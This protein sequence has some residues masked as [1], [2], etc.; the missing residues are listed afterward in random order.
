MFRRFAS[1][2]MTRAMLRKP[3]FV[4][5]G[6]ERPYLL[7]WWLIPRNPIFNVYLHQFFRSDDD[8]ALHDHPW[9]NCSIVLDGGYIE[10][11]IAAGGIHHR[12]ERKAGDIV[13]RLPRTAHRIELHSKRV[14]NTQDGKRTWVAM[15]QPCWTLFITGPRIR[16]WGFHCPDA[17]WVH[18]R[19]FTDPATNGTTVGKG[20]GAAL[21]LALLSAVSVARAQD[22]LRIDAGTQRVKYAGVVAKIDEPTETT[23]AHLHFV[24]VPVLP[25][26][27]AQIKPNGALPPGAQVF[28]LDFTRPDGVTVTLDCHAPT[29]AFDG[30]YFHAHFTCEAQP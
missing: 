4:I 24:Q 14:V 13:C 18:W 29:P 28:S 12:I 6:N 17:G 30:Q 3:D 26:G 11:R 2:L 20:C 19:K 1:W 25:I 9:V 7:R 8:R 5:G 22:M 23:P 10:H 15:E 16:S 21:V 27:S